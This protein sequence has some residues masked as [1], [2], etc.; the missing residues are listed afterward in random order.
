MQSTDSESDDEIEMLVSP[1]P[2][3]CPYIENS[4]KRGLN[5]TDTGVRLVV[6]NEFRITP[7]SEVN[8]KDFCQ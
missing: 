7:T 1:K 4:S 8:S 6:P 3:P 2:S 5:R